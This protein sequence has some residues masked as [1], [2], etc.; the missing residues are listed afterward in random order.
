M[1]MEGMEYAEEA[2]DACKTYLP[3]DAQYKR[4]IDITKPECCY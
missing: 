3:D 4:T 2:K 1:L